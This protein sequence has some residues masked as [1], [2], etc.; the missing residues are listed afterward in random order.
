MSLPQLWRFA[1]DWYGG[2]LDLPWRKRSAAEV[3]A[4]FGLHGLEGPFWS[5]AGLDR[6]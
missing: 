3:A 1:R 4:L 2:Y 6:E 5:L